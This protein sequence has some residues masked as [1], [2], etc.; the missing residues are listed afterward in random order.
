MIVVFDGLSLKKSRVASY[1]EGSKM[2]YLCF[3]KRSQGT[4]S[5][6]Q[7]RRRESQDCYHN[8]SHQRKPGVLGDVNVSS[9]APIVAVEKDEK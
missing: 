9:E 4:M 2:H 8:L 6:V 7:S 5:M 3:K 1:N